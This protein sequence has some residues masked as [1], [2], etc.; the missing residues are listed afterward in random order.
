MKFRLVHSALLLV[1]FFGVNALIA[2]KVNIVGTVVDSTDTPQPWSTAALIVVNEE[3][4]SSLANYA[5]TNREGKFAIIGVDTGKYVLQVTFAGMGT[6]SENVIVTETMGDIDVGTI[7][8]SEDDILNEVKV[9]ADFIPIRIKADTVEFNA[10][11]YGT[12]PN[13]TVEDLLKKMPGFEV[14]E[15][16]NLVVNGETVG[17]VLVDGKEF[18]GSDG[19]VAIKNLP[20]DAIDKVQVFDKK[21][22][23]AEF[24]GIDDGERTKAVDLKLKKDKKKG[25]FGNVMGGYGLNDN[26]ESVYNSKLSWNRFDKKMQISLIGTFNNIN[27]TGFSYREFIDFVG[28]MQK[29]S[30]RVG[31]GWRWSGATG[32]LPISNGLGDGQAVTASG[33]LNFNYSFKKGTELNVSYLYYQI[34]NLLE[35]NTRRQNFIE[36][37][38]FLTTDDNL[39]D[40]RNLSHRVNMRF[41]HAFSKNTEM[42]ITGE[43]SFSNGN[44]FS[45]ASANTF[46]IGDDNLIQNGSVRD[47]TTDQENYSGSVDFNLKHKMK[48][49]GRSIFLE[50]SVGLDGNDNRMK[51]DGSNSFLLNNTLFNLPL[52]QNQL[53]QSN[54]LTYEAEL[55]YTE[56]LKGDHYLEFKTGFFNFNGDVDYSVYDVIPDTSV[57]FNPLLSS[58]YVPGFLTYHGGVNL[59]RI[60]TKYSLTAGVDVQYSEMDGQLTLL[61][62]AI[63]KTFLNLLPLL[64]L[65]INLAQG[66]R[67]NIEFETEATPPDIAQVQPVVDNTNPT[68][69]FV[70]NP[71]LGQE[72][73]Y[74]ASVN[75]NGFNPMKMGGWFTGIFGEYT[76][77]NIV[78]ATTIDERLIRTTTPVNVDYSMN[79]Y[80]YLNRTAEIPKVKMRY[81]VGLNSNFN[82][83]IIFI[84]GVE[85]ISTNWFSGIDLRLMN[86]NTDVIDVLVSLKANY[87]NVSYNISREF[88]QDF[89]TYSGFL[90][91]SYKFAK[92]WLVKLDF[93]YTLLSQEVIG[94]ATSIP[95]L[96][97]GLSHFVMGGRGE[98]KLYAFDIFN[99]NQS[100]VRNVN[101]NYLEETQKNII[102]RYYML[103]FTWNFAGKKKDGGMDHMRM[104]RR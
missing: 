55:A 86:K 15:E 101:L 65:N 102:Q 30:Q 40:V 52:I 5:L 13:A 57:T 49:K 89:M 50:G 95:L 3:G 17:K 75:Y 29:F 26:T 69:I 77:D 43:V 37:G 7:M 97:A 84:N 24:T 82:N 18:F 80:G 88:N 61:D 46:T 104:W 1:F 98:V 44:M 31:R 85:N 51:L 100:V 60:R 38:S 73:T 48:K 32:G 19:K 53:N 99:Q 27:Q 79:I 78:N 83:G 91:A 6:H 94:S 72:Y 22:E 58:K 39:Q 92:N 68:N 36:E 56:P 9:S 63:S 96:S 74:S 12:D 59:M 20:A 21:S 35:E 33:G 76:T 10:N 64:K 66:K 23:K 11:A 87:N 8:L 4:D 25:A 47:F 54:E 41:D 42:T 71:D 2:Q 14:D 93:D 67:I 81:S 28:G 45:S 103:S 70:G 90:D 16:G 34:D 62:T